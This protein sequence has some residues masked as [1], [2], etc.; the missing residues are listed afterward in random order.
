LRNRKLITPLLAQ[1]L[2]CQLA[3]LIEFMFDK[4]KFSILKQVFA[5]YIIDL[6]LPKSFESCIRLKNKFKEYAATLNEGIMP[7]YIKDARGEHDRIMEDD[8]NTNF[9]AFFYPTVCELDE[10]IFGKSNS[11][12]DF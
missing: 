2:D 3:A 6:D 10:K 5:F 9:P 4:I 12:N 8:G 11:T 1:E 7:V